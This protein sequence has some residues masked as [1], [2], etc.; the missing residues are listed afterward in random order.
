MSEHVTS[1]NVLTDSINLNPKIP[2]PS[3]D[4]LNKEE[5]MEPEELEFEIKIP[6]QQS[7]FEK[8]VAGENNIHCMCGEDLNL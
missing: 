3:E 6:T 8:N 2:N 7:I 4:I 5:S 1:I